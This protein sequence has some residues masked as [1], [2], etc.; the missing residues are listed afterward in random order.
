M[1]AG[2]STELRSSFYHSLNISPST[3]VQQ[4]LGSVSLFSDL[5]KDGGFVFCGFYGAPTHNRINS[6]KDI[7]IKP[8][9]LHHI[10]RSLLVCLE[11]DRLFIDTV[12]IINILY[13]LCCVA[14]FCVALRYVMLRCAA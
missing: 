11:L 12:Y 9:R 7:T 4:V 6:A 3:L 13:D 2:T 14:L 8:V 5:W 10:L 1:A